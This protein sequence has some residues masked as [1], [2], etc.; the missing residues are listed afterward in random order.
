MRVL[1]TLTDVASPPRRARQLLR[2]LGAAFGVAVIVGNTIG[3]GILRTPGDIARRLPTPSLFLGVWIAGGIYALLGAVSI[4]ELGAMIPQ[5]GGQYVLVRRGLG[6]YPGFVVGWSDWISHLRPVRRDRH[7]RSA[8][9]SACWCRRH[10]PRNG[11]RG[12]G[13]HRRSRSML[14]AGHPTGG[15]AASSS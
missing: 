12:G 13:G 4:A 1:L 6:G 14:L 3:V 5:S 10:R 11:G 9:I 2:V 15:D 7:G 8:S